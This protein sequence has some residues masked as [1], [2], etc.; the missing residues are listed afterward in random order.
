MQSTLQQWLQPVKAC[1]ATGRRR[2]IIIHDSDDEGSAIIV[3]SQQ[4]GPLH[5]HAEDHAAI[6]APQESPPLSDSDDTDGP[7]SRRARRAAIA[8]HTR[9][10]VI[11]QYQL[12]PCRVFLQE[13]DVRHQHIE[14]DDDIWVRPLTPNP[15]QVSLLNVDAACALQFILICARSPFHNRATRLPSSMSRP[16]R[17]KDHPRCCQ[18][19]IT[20][21]ILTR[22]SGC[23]PGHPTRHSRSL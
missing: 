4:R 23:A 15:Q 12:Q 8:A 3:E 1:Q 13:T 6:V 17:H 10:Q 2:H 21:T 16:M 7:I 19:A 20:V 18:T 11:W 9:Q 22:T 14:S 5:P